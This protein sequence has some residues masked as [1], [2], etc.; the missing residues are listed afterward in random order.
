VENE[1]YELLE[2]PEIFLGRYMH[3]FRVSFCRSAGDFFISLEIRYMFNLQYL[4]TVK[5]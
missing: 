5:K 2:L 1:E 4:Y 3:D